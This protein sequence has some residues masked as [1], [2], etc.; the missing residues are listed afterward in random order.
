MI[1]RQYGRYPI[2]LAC[3]IMFRP[4]GVKTTSNCDF[5]TKSR[6]KEPLARSSMCGID[7]EM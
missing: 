1:L 7:A 4:P 3:L 5:K 6:H 2:G